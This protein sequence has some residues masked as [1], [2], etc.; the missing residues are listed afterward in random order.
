[1]GMIVHPY[2]PNT[3]ET[4]SRVTQD[5]GLPRLYS[6]ILSQKKKKSYSMVHS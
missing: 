2:N 1:M 6:K 4:E 5:Q 3:K